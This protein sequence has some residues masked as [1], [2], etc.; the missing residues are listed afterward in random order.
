[1]SELEMTVEALKLCVPPELLEKA[2]YKVKRLHA[3]KP[4]APSMVSDCCGEKKRMERIIREL[5]IEVGVPAVIKGYRY[6]IT[7]IKL[8]VENPEY[9][10][11]VTK[12]LYSAVAK[13][14]NS[15]YGRVERAIRYGIEVA[16][17]QGDVDVH[18]RI[19]GNSVSGEK[20]KPT[21]SEFL[22]RLADIVRERMEE[23]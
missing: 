9:I 15:T 6:S 17:E 22:A 7:A 23:Q 16:W 21:N 10:D 8:I 20:G 3:E 19:F 2:L 5:L 14:H 1:M 11:Q 18:Y 4:A 13:I 12:R